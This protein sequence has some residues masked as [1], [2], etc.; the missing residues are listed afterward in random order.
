[1]KL[2]TAII[3]FA[4]A[5]LSGC[6]TNHD[7]PPRKTVPTMYI[8]DSGQTGWVKVVYN[9]PDEKELPVQ[10]GFAVAHIGQDLKLFTRSRMNPSWDESQFYYQTPD[11]KRVRLSSAD[12]PSR[13]IW[14]Q[15]KTTDAEGEREA[16]FVGNQGQ[17]SQDLKTP[18]SIGGGLV[19]AP[20]ESEEPKDPEQPPDASKVLTELPKQ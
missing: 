12:S 1:V 17:L 4:L 8:I 14:A 7:S 5:G 20:A 6:G 9:V 13:L 16:F 11:G 19:H 18:Q 2:T 15:D 3:G 10:N